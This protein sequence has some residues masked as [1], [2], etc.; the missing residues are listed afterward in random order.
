VNA[1][2]V[3]TEQVQLQQLLLLLLRCS[4]VLLGQAGPSVTHTL[5]V[6]IYQSGTDQGALTL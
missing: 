3:G 4:L 6:D 2:H 5:Q 1:W